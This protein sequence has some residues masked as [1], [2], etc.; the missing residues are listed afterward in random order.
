MSAQLPSQ[1]PPVSSPP[2]P[3]RYEA[4]LVVAAFP[5]DDLLDALPEDLAPHIHTIQDS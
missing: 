3:A 1:Q 5:K 2:R 4:P